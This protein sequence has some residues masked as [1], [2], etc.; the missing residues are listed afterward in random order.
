[1]ITRDNFLDLVFKF[2]LVLFELLFEWFG[3]RRLVT[4]ID[5]PKYKK[6]VRYIYIKK[7]CLN[8]VSVS[9]NKFVGSSML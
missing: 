4:K 6:T 5:V 9:V 2:L 7:H 8:N 3:G 1:M